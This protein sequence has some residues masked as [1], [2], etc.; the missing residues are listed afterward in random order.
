[1]SFDETTEQ[2]VKFRSLLD[3]TVFSLAKS[4]IYKPGCA[5]RRLWSFNRPLE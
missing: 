5:Q 3:S 4:E 2:I 1:M